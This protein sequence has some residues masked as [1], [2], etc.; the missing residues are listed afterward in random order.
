MRRGLLVALV[1]L[2][3]VSGAGW[4]CTVRAV[5]VAPGDDRAVE[6]AVVQVIRA[7]GRTI[8]AALPA[9]P[10]GPIG[11]ALV[12]AHRR[13]V[14]VRVIVEEGSGD[15]ARAAHAWLSDAGISIL[16]E[17]TLALLEHRFAVIDGV[18]VIAGSYDWAMRTPQS[19]YGH[20]L[21]IDCSSVASPTSVASQFRQTFERL[22]ALVS[23]TATSP[24]PAVPAMLPG[25]SPVVIHLVDP[26]GE[27][28]WLLNISDAPV[29]ITGWSL[30][31]LE[32]RY[33]FPAD[34]ILE[35]D[36]PFAI[37]MATYNPTEDPY[38]LYLNDEHD[39][40]Y[41]V[42]PDGRIADERVW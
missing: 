38:G 31:D 32:G 2:S 3:M 10:Y 41:L 22:W 17:A 37:C 36:D 24:T 7:A 14:A 23:P 4:A 20:A 40:V 28:I 33:V 12:D 42:T 25:L 1:L 13:G 6:A 9:L 34:T 19:R 29:D 39:E 16:Y 15:A 21:L 27:C 8:D 35:P 5:F 30:N 26:A 18:R 11:E